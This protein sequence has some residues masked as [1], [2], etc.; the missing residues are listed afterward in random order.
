VASW[1]GAA[2]LLCLPSRNEGMPNVVVEAL[3]SG[4]PVVATAV[5]GLPDVIVEGENGF[6]A[7]SGE[8][9]ALAGALWRALSVTWD[10]ARITRSAEAMTWAA[11]AQRNLDFLAT[12][13]RRPL[14]VE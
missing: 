7:P 14:R 5:G 9:S 3:A 8:A 12:A 11:L 13:V 1:I 6:L 2:D 4:V 10:V